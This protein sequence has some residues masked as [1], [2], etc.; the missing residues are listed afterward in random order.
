[1]TT[2]KIPEAI[3]HHR[4]YRDKFSAKYAHRI[5]T[6]GVGHNLPQEAPPALAQAVVDVDRY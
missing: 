4:R 2:I 6:S 3:S 1:M 5:I